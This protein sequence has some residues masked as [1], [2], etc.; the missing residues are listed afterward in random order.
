MYG[1]SGVETESFYDGYVEALLWVNT[2]ADTSDGVEPVD[3]TE[4]ALSPYASRALRQDVEDFLDERTER[5]V[6]AAVRRTPGYGFASAGHDLALTRNRHGA[7]YWDRG[8]G[9]LG[10]ALTV[11]AQTYGDRDLYLHGSGVVGV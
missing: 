2:Y 7:G 10:E 3:A 4:C 6:R 11:I 5:L 9:M 1:M 8:M